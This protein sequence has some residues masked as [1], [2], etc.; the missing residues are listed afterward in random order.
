MTLL[1][2]LFVIGQTWTGTIATLLAIV[3]LLILRRFLATEQRTRGTVSLTFL[4]FALL[5]GLGA[6][7]ALKV[8]SYTVWGALSFLG[9]LSFVCGLT[10]LAGLVVFDFVFNRTRV[11][12]PS[13]LRG[14][15]HISVITVIVLTILYQRGLD[16]LSLITTSAVLTAVIG[17]ALQ[18]TIAN[19]FAGLALH[20]DRTLGIGD[21]VQAG[22]LV[23]RINEIKWRST[24]LWTEDGDLVIVPNGR[25]LDAEVQNLSRPDDVHRMWIKIGFHYRHPPNE[26][27]RILLDAVCGSL[28]VR[29][30]PAPDCLLLDFADSA[31]TYALRYWINDYTHHAVIESEVRT[32][33]WYAARRGGLEIPFP[34]RTLILPTSASETV[35]GQNHTGDDV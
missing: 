8:S 34:I 10:G 4:C 11:R 22:M 3:T 25:L 27:K 29:T 14:L 33:I 6:T 5:F 16:P 12:V 7:V 2:Q 19:A 32:R 9:L 26:V 35:V 21:W 18:S 31:I 20:A 30:E 28:G 13:I 24:S 1:N 23:G 17:L 15:I